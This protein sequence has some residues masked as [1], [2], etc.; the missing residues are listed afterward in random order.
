MEQ[1]IL[2]LNRLVWAFM[3]GA[4]ASVLGAMAAGSVWPALPF[5]ACWLGALVCLVT[6]DRLLS[7]NPAVLPG[8]HPW[9]FFRDPR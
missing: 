2:L 1:R 4:A 8:P 6:R 9:W 3:G 5:L 7:E